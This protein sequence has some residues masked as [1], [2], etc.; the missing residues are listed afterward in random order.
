MMNNKQ[1]RYR[2]ILLEDMTKDELIEAF[3][4]LHEMYLAASEDL[5]AVAV[6]ASKITKRR[7]A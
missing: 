2:G 7:A 6:L 4:Y 3:T 1:L 5:K